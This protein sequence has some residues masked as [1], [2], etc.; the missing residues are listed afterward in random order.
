[1][2]TAS[3]AVRFARR[4]T[5]YRS[6]YCLNYVQT[7]LAAPWSGPSAIYAWQHAKDKHRADKHPPPGV[8][9]FWSGGRYG[10]IAISVG[11]GRVRSTDWPSSGRVGEVPIETLSRAWHKHYEGWSTD[12]GGRTIPGIAA[13][14]PTSTRPNVYVNRLRFGVTDSDSV[15]HAQRRLIALG[16]A[17]PAGPTGTYGAQTDDAVRAWQRSIGDRVDRSR[18]SSIGPRQTARLFRG[19][20]A[21]IHP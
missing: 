14:R 1:M 4:F 19:T 8:P 5:R 6:G 7:M 17:I 20:S 18:H 16:F 15:R 11:G 21:R 10:H 12:L 13:A 9:V 3:E 2:R